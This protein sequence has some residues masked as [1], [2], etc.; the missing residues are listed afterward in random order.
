MSQAATLV[1]NCDHLA[2]LKFPA[3]MPYAFTEHG[4]L[5]HGR[6]IFA[7]PLAP[8]FS[9]AVAKNRGLSPIYLSPIYPVFNLVS[10]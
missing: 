3:A 2:N 9:P 7:V 4:A 8:T 10:S 5:M 6:M 1:A